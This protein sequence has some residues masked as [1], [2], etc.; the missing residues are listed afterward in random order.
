MVALTRP[1]AAV[2]RVLRAV[3]PGILWEVPTSE[4]LVALTFDDGPHP[5]TTPQLL[6][7]LAGHG[8]KATFFV[9]GRQVEGN[10]TILE[11][12]VAEGHELGNH[13]MTP[14]RSVTLGSAAF[15]RDLA[16][17]GELLGR[18]GPVRYFRPASGWFT[19]AMLHA[20]A[21]LGCRCALG[22]I[23]TTDTDSR[24]PARTAVRLS[25]RIRPGA[26]VVLHE[27]GSGRAGIVEVTRA[28]LDDLVDRGYV[29]V[30]LSEL[31]RREHP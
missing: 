21:R 18:F 31:S 24:R 17:A 23:S 6:D 19:P 9:I 26:V 11:R 30:T 7:L 3:L 20:A 10:E 15:A 2:I 16:A 28:L 25:R 14:A 1:G 29:M 27:G 22:S 4:R 8:A 5:A 13:T 12:L